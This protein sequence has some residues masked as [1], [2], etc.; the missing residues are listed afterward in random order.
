MYSN[1]NNEFMISKGFSTEEELFNSYQ[2]LDTNNPQNLFKTCCRNKTSSSKSEPTLKWD[3]FVDNF[4]LTSPYNFGIESFNAGSNDIPAENINLEVVNNPNEIQIANYNIYPKIKIKFLCPLPQGKKVFAHLID[5][6][7][8]KVIEDGFVSGHT[9]TIE[10][11]DRE[12][13]YFHSLKLNKIGPIK[14]SLSRAKIHQGQRV[15]RIRFFMEENFCI[16]Q[17]FQVKSSCSQLNESQKEIVR[18]PKKRRELLEFSFC[19]D[20]NN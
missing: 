19:N 3:F 13:I 20:Q 11:N 6:N 12:F 17:P 4:F 7:T 14:K 2:D 5:S 16:S 9:V 10:K 15:F 8:L 1:N 18:P